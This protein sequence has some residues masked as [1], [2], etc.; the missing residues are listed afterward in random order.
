M[1]NLRDFVK[2][3]YSQNNTLEEGRNNISK[4]ITKIKSLIY[5]YYSNP[6]ICFHNND[7][8]RL[9]KI[10][11]YKFK[12][13]INDMFIKD[14]AKIPS[15]TLIKN[16]FDEIDL[17]KDGI[18]DLNEWCKAFGNYNSLLDP[19]KEK[20]SN[21]SDFF[22]KKF[23]K[24]NNFKSVDKIES[25][26]KVLREWDTSRDVSAIYKFLYKNRKA[27]KDRIKKE[28]YLIKINESEFVHAK[29][30]IEILKDI[31]PNLKL[32]LTQWNMIAKIA[33][34]ERS[35]DLININDFFNL[36]EISTKNMISHPLMK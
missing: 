20:V 36:I 7:P 25:N 5:K 19:D 16:A 15:F 12:N 29:N 31:L 24:K 18:L 6:I 13:I 27:I 2:F 28:S 21:C 14:E 11:L 22:G 17:R 30:F 32:S 34:I 33:Q 4:I 23:K 3:L 1:I 8:K 10:D 26:R 9:G 35:D